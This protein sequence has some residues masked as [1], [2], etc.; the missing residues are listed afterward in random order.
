ML[1]VF[2]AQDGLFRRNAPVNIQRIIQNAD[3]SVLLPGD[4]VVALVL[5]RWPFHSIRQNRAQNRAAQKLAMVFFRQFHSYM[6]S[7]SRTSFADVYSHVQHGTFHAAH[8]FTLRVRRTL[9]MQST[10]YSVGRHTLVVLHK[11]DFAHLSSNSRCE[12]DSKK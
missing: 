1:G 11:I 6:L 5:G 7:V 10:H 12:N 3:A 2:F 8:Q 9:K 4:K